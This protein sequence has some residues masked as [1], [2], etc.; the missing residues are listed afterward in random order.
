LI[1]IERD[2]KRFF[3]PLSSVGRGTINRFTSKKR[4]K[5]TNIGRDV[6]VTFLPAAGNRAE[7][8]KIGKETSKRHQEKEL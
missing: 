2:G 1:I 4:I 3:A 8:V 7:A 6:Y 5:E